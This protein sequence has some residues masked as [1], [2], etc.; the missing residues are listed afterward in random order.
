MDEFQIDNA[1][2][3]SRVQY[4]KKFTNY[5]NLCLGSKISLKT[6]DG[7]DKEFFVLYKYSNLKDCKF[8]PVLENQVHGKAYHIEGIN[9]ERQFW[10][11]IPATSRDA[12]FNS[13]KIDVLYLPVNYAHAEN[14]GHFLVDRMPHYYTFVKKSQNYL[15]LS[16]RHMDILQSWN[17]ANKS[18]SFLAPKFELAHQMVQRNQDFLHGMGIRDVM[19]YEEMTK[20]V[21]FHY[22]FTGYTKPEGLSV[23]DK[24]QRHFEKFFNV[25][26]KCHQDTVVFIQRQANRIILNLEALVNMTHNLMPSTQ[27]KVMYLEDYTVQQQMQIVHCA[28]ILIGV[29]GSGMVWYKYLPPGAAFVEIGYEDW[30]NN[31]F[32]PTARLRRPDLYFYNMMCRGVISDEVYKRKAK[33]WLGYTGNITSEIQEQVLLKN[34]EYKKISY[35]M[36]IWMISNCEC[37]SAVLEGYMKAYLSKRSSANV[38]EPFYWMLLMFIILILD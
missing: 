34:K 25:T 33:E 24:I 15:P 29:Q 8:P 27:V 35:V 28:Q 26:E 16:L 17:W 14:S 23:H 2:V 12:C 37:D 5:Q 13:R 30:I 11:V 31:F 32:T 22:G 7:L 18:V 6:S 19:F 10:V 20:P 9:G 4:Y 21:C 1:L 3:K 36:T 38:L